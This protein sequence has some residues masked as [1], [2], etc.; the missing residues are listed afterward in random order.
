MALET[1]GVN[2][3]VEFLWGRSAATTASS[4]DPPNPLHEGIFMSAILFGSI[5]SLADTSELQRRAFNEAF[6]SHGLDWNWSRAEYISMLRSNGGVNRIADYAGATGTDIDAAA[7]HAT[8][9][10]FFQKLLGESDLA[11]RPGVLETLATAKENDLKIGFVTTTSAENISALLGALAPDVTKDSFDIIVDSSDVTQPKPD[12]ASYTFAIEKLGVSAQ[13]CV[14]IE[15]NE[16]G[17]AAASTAGVTCIA[18]PNENTAQGDFSAAVESV[19]ALD[20]GRVT[21][22]AGA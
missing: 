1:S 4:C 19:S 6:A 21:A 5:S 14:A 13:N 20:A 10:E 9:S 8:K 15:D 7:V 18:F 17:V 16:G 2:A 3:T 11:P 12:A 22:L